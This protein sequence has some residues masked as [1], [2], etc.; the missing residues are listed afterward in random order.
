MKKQNKYVVLILAV[1]I[2]FFLAYIIST[3]VIAQLF[4]KDMQLLDSATVEID[5]CHLDSN[6]KF[7]ITDIESKQELLDLLK[8]NIS[9]LRLKIT[10]YPLDSEHNTYNIII[11]DKG[12]R[13]FYLSNIEPNFCFFTGENLDYYITGGDVLADYLDNYKR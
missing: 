6:T 3:Y 11:F 13:Y 8:S 10:D 7:S 2:V 5:V 9:L 12:Y 4:Q 1:I